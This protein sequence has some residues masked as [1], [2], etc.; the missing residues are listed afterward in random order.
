MKRLLPILISSF[1]LFSILIISGCTIGGSDKDARNVL[2]SYLD[3]VTKGDYDAAY[4]LL[5]KYDQQKISK[6]VFVKWREA[7][8]KITK[9][10]S[11]S[12]GKKSDKF[13]KME[14]FGVVYTKSYGFDVNLKIDK[15][16][17]NADLTDMYE[18][19]TYKQMVVYEDGTWKMGLFYEDLESRTSKYNEL[20]SENSKK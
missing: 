3:N 17:E 8:A 19:E 16:I 18:Q 9:F 5:C 13:G 20:I 6:D 2:S 14:T 11:Y 7:V 4:D 12:I 10:D 1:L 15:L